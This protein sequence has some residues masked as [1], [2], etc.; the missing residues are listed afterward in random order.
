V[1]IDNVVANWCRS[2]S[3][4]T[5]TAKSGQPDRDLT[6]QRRDR[7]V[8]VVLPVANTVA[9]RTIWPPD[10]V[11]PRPRDGDLAPHIRQR[12]LRL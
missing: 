1:L 9:A 3:H 6:E 7:V 4:H 10:D 2:R 12:Q 11:V 5:G 8:P